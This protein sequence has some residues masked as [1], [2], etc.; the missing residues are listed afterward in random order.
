MHWLVPVVLVLTGNVGWAVLISLI[1][2]CLE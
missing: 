1:F 2:I